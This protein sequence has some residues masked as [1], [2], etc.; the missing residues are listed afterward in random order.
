MNQRENKIGKLGEKELSKWATQMDCTINKSIEDEEGWDF[1]IEFPP[2]FSPD[3][4]P[5][6]LDKVDSPLKCWIQVKSTDDSLGKRSVNL[7]NWLRLVKTPYPAFFLVVEFNGKD[8]PQ[9]AFLVH[10]GEEYIRKVLKRLRKAGFKKQDK[11]HK[12][13]MQ[14]TYDTNNEILS[15]NGEGLKSSIKKYVESTD[16]YMGWKKRLVE[17]VGYENGGYEMKTTIIL[18]DGENTDPLEPF[19]DLSLGLISHL[20][21]TRVEVKDMRFGIEAPELTKIFTKKGILTVDNEP[22]SKGLIIFRLDDYSKEVKIQVDLFI[23]T[24]FRF[25]LDHH[26]WKVRFTA[27]FFNLVFNLSNNKGTLNFKWP[28]FDEKYNLEDLLK[29]SQ[30]M[31]LLHQAETKDREIYSEIWVK[32]SCVAKGGQI[33]NTY[34]PQE[35]T[36]SA[37]KVEIAWH[38]ANQFDIQNNIRLTLADLLSQKLL[39]PIYLITENQKPRFRLTYW[40]EK[41]SRHTSTVTYCPN[42]LMLPLGQYAIL[43]TIAVIGSPQKTGNDIDNMLEWI[44][45]S[46]NVHMYGKTCLSRSN[47]EEIKLRAKDMLETTIKQIDDSVQI[48][49][50]EDVRNLLEI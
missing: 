17:E 47:S 28:Q 15:L 6:P 36:E 13:K 7:R 16:V 33:T 12:K 21:T 30:I 2:D 35:I 50:S 22:V 40:M 46:N 1:I 49:L 11:L 24:G 31:L 41:D 43:F 4:E 32:E 3:G 9:K 23:P 20:E 48:M 27:P 39:I 8:E 14:L 37:H 42:L 19:I 25:E 5:L 34:I 45:I 44:L 29:I 10:I 38:I 18:P 26:Y